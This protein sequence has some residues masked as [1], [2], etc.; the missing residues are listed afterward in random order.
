LT[1]SIRA[2]DRALDVLLCF[3]KQTPALS[4]T[5]IAEMIVM[6]KSTVHRLLLTLE[7]KRFVQRDP[8]TGQYTPGIRLLQLAYLTLEKNDLRELAAPFMRRLLD[9]QLETVDLCIFDGFEVV[10]LD[11]LE[12]PQ[13]IRLAAAPGQRLPAFCTASGKAFLAFMPDDT[14]KRILQQGMTQYTQFTPLSAQA[15]LDDLHSTF[16][17]GFAYSAQEYEDGIN[18][19]SAPI[20]DADGKALAAIAVAG[21]AYRLPVE[22]M[23]EIGPSVM[24]TAQEIAREIEMANRPV[25][26]ANA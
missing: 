6:N 1:D 3:S 5:Q 12:S 16:K 25:G 4:M 10:F 22:R 13:R 2:V 19:V 24:A 17:R 15:V 21:P 23:L 14:V 20:L 26:R 18:A 8:A 9:Q 7:K 11:V